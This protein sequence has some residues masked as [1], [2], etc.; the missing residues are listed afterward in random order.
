MAARKPRP[1][2]LPDELPATFSY[3]AARAAGMSNALIYQ[4]RDDGAITQVARGLYRRGDADA[5]VDLDLLEIAQKAPRATICLTSAL[6]HH[7]LIDDNPAAIHIALP[8]GSRY[9]EV[10]PPVTWHSFDNATFDI[11]R[12]TIDIDAETV[13][14][15]Y[16]P[17]RCIVDAFRL[18]H[19]V[20][21]ET[22]NIALRRWLRSHGNHPAALCE[23][24][25]QFP[26]TQ[27]KIR[28]TLEVLVSD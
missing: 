10:T 25:R 20:G 26:R 5:H 13:T 19:I 18:R 15:I 21:Y 1:Y 16:G 28:E 7:N 9:P 8:R 14:G 22:A 2:R 4:L 27:R 24:A 11:G 3:A 17:E 23:F 6:A 12:E